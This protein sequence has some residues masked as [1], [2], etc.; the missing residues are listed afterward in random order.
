MTPNNK[1]ESQNSNPDAWR[2]DYCGRDV[3]EV[4]AD[5]HYLWTDVM[6]WICGDCRTNVWDDSDSPYNK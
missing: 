2:C 3:S 4:D 5:Q 1:K 6:G